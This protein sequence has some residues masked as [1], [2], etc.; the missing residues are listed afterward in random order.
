[1]YVVMITGGVG[2]GKS[3]L[4]NLLC[5]RGAVSIDLDAIAGTLMDNEPQMVAELAGEFGPQILNGDGGVD[6][7][8]LNELAC[9]SAAAT[10]SMNEIVFPYITR[11]ANEYILDVHCT[12]RTHAKVLAIE[13]AALTDVP[14]FAELADE[15]IA[16]EAP[17][18]QRLARC[19]ESGMDTQ[20][21]INRIARQA[22]DTER[23]A[24]VDT[25]CDNGGSVEDLVAWVDEW[26]ASREEHFDVK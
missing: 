12:P 13:V 16:I 17:Q 24:I 20:D 14:Q 15:V 21:A 4:L 2:C 18:L 23:A 6:R 25:I 3:T 5:E 11:E 10:R 19:V 9:A 8:A 22:S 7:D 26:W 1:M